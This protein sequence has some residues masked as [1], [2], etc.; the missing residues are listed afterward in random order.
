MKH[1]LPKRWLLVVVVALALCS[2]TLVANQTHTTTVP[3]LRVGV[4]LYNQSDIFVSSIASN[5]ELFAPQIERERNMKMTLSIVDANGSQSTQNEQIS[6]F[7]SMHYD[8]LCVNIVDRT[9]AAVLIDSAKQANIPIFFFNREPVAEDLMRW[10]NAFYVGGDSREAGTLQGQMVRSLYQ[11]SPEK[12]DKNGD[13]VV[14]YVLLEG[15][16]GHQDTILRSDYCVRTLQTSGIAL[17]KLGGDTANWQMGQAQVKMQGWLHNYGSQIELVFSNNDEMA[18]GA[19]EACRM[20]G[21][22]DLPVIVGVDGTAAA[23]SA[24]QEGSLL[25]TVYNDGAGQAEVMLTAVCDLLLAGTLPETNQ[26]RLP[27]RA[28]TAENV[29]EFIAK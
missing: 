8:M 26:I 19:L 16:A 1:F 10:D 20:A 2:L 13:G 17:Q 27:Y 28:V 3:T 4:A 14:Q 24:I 25:G 29:T 22:Q 7:I 9:A 5:M 23:L 11:Q 12:L 21:L 6:H 15:E 18:L